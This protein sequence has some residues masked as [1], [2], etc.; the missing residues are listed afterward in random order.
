MGQRSTLLRKVLTVLLV[1][2]GA[3][4]GALA[5]QTLSFTLDTTENRAPEAQA[6]AAMLA[7]IGVDAQVRVWQSARAVAG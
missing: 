2:G 5:Q 7:E 3:S 1:L 6:I 4:T